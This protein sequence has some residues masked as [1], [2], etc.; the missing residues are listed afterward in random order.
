MSEQCHN[1][2]RGV[3]W[4]LCEA[5]LAYFQRWSCSITDSQNLGQQSQ[6][7]CCQTDAHLE[8]AYP[9]AVNCGLLLHRECLIYSRILIKGINERAVVVLVD[10]LAVLSTRHKFFKS[11]NTFL[12][13]PCHDSFLNPFNLSCLFGYQT[14]CSN[15]ATTY[16]YVSHNDNIL[17]DGFNKCR[18]LFFLLLGQ[19]LKHD[20]WHVEDSLF[21]H[22][23]T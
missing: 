1:P 15:E 12:W 19:T 10:S 4:H 13:C 11:T 14:Y 21:R 20:Y 9:V 3:Q 16:L 22:V 7:P 5:K 6:S 17:I 2:H 8:E 23:E 18:S